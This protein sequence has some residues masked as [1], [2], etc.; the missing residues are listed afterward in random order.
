M[1][2]AA[3][4]MEAERLET[5]AV[6]PT[7]ILHSTNSLEPSL[8]PPG[9]SSPNH[10]TA[11]ETIRQRTA[12][13]DPADLVPHLP[14]AKCELQACRQARPCAS[15]LL[16][17]DN[18]RTGGRRNSLDTIPIYHRLEVVTSDSSH[19]SESTSTLSRNPS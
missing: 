16:P 6:L 7:T 9:P 17:P 18:S 13:L 3:L 2:Q 10:P 12:L 4:V 1:A 19:V 15:D 14:S 8:S 5:V 11:K